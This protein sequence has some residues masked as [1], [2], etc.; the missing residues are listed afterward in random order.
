MQIRRLKVQ[1][2]RSLHSANTAELHADEAVSSFDAAPGVLFTFDPITVLIGPNDCG[3][4]SVLD[5]LEIVLS[6]GTPDSDDFHRPLPP[7]QD[8]APL[9][10]VHPE[11]TIE[12]AIEFDLHSERDAPAVEYAHLGT[13]TLRVV[14]SPTATERYY[15]GETPVDP[16]LRQDF[17]KM[18]AADQIALIQEIDAAALDGLSNVQQRAE[19]LEQHAE[20]SP[21]HVE[22]IPLPRGFQQL[23]P[24]FERYSAMDYDDPAGLVLKTLRQVY[25]S[26]ILE[27]VDINGTQT[28]RPVEA[29]R[30]IKSQVEQRINQEIQQ[31]LAFIQR[32][33][34]RVRTISYDPSI[35]FSGGLRA[36]Q[37]QIDDGHGLTY[38]SKLGDGTKRRMFIAVVD[39]DREVTLAQASTDSTLPTIIRGYDEPDTNLDYQA[40]RRMYQSIADIV[41]APDSRVQAVVCTHSPRLVDQAPARAIRLLSW[42]GGCTKVSQLHT[43]DDPDIEQFLIELAS[44]LGLTNTLMFYERCFLL[45]EGATEQN[46]LP[47]LY[48]TAY[49]HSLLEDGIRIINVESNG[50]IKEFLK[51][52][53]RNRHEITLILADLDAE[54]SPRRP[55]LTRQMLSECRFSEEFI[56]THLHLV[57]RA[58]IGANGSEFEASFPDRVIAEA[59]QHAWPKGDGQWS[60]G[61]VAQMRTEPDKK[62]SDVLNARVWDQAGEDSSKW[63]KPAFGS[64]LGRNCPTIGIPAEIAELFRHAR[65]IA[66]CPREG[67]DQ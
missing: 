2:F 59:L 16:R 5:L 17:A 6:D 46:A 23:L 52:M 61:D 62:F 36:G 35:D 9:V 15:L 63:T 38:L 3:K 14:F 56:T 45:V 48:R 18:R 41:A 66:G 49:R 20:A 27:E 53:S 42:S 22:W 29:L 55:K 58:E 11:Q 54:A 43:D 67:E 39:W 30:T 44:E 19:W 34:P 40:Q 13:I 32:Y 47:L 25:E 37:F 33:I 51:L 28:R 7:Q 60:E 26:V 31:L 24:R 12:A 65:R 50:A 8:N 1:G 21:H 57:P 4:S 64:A 10:T